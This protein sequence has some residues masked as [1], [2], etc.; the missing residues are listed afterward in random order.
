[1]DNVLTDI[2]IYK[3][4]K[5]KTALNTIFF[6]MYHTYFCRQIFYQND[7][8]ELYSYIFP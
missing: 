7:H 6:F 2:N 8:E 3:M 1:M 5:I 4:I